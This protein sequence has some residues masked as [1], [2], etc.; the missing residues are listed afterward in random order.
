MLSSSIDPHESR[1]H[2]AVDTGVVVIALKTIAV[3]VS[4]R[5]LQ[6]FSDQLTLLGMQVGVV[7]SLR[8]QKH[9]PIFLCHLLWRASWCA[10]I[11]VHNWQFCDQFCSHLSIVSVVCCSESTEDCDNGV[12]RRAVHRDRRDGHACHQKYG[13]D[14]ERYTKVVKYRIVPLVY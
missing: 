1:R 6:M 2:I 5:M 11:T 4:P 12:S 10:A 9:S 13:K 3:P 14:W 7:S 8:I